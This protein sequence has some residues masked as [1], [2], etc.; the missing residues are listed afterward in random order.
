MDIYFEKTMIYELTRE[1]QN[2]NITLKRVR[3]RRCYKNTKYKVNDRI[4]ET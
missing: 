1:K 2:N 3:K 4:P